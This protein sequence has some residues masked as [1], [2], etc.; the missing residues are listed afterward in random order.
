MFGIGWGELLI[1]ALILLVVVGPDKMPTFLKTT[2]KGIR[3]F[4]RTARELRNATG[5]DRIL[6]DRPPPP[7][8]ITK[9]SDYEVSREVPVVG[10]D[11]EFARS[12]VIEHEDEWAQE[13]P[14]PA[15][16]IVFA[17]QHVHEDP[18]GVQELV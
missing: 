9:L 14:V 15:V 5:I 1:I 7:K 10:A 17:Q 11:I 16:D 12:V 6:D 13:V 18:D 4:R 8:R 3:D 2:V